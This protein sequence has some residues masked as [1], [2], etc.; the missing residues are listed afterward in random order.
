MGEIA[1]IRYSLKADNV[2]AEQAVQNLFTPGQLSINAIWRK[3]N[4]IEEADDEVG[5]GL[6]Q[7][8]RNELQLVV[9]HPDRGSGGGDRCGSGSESTVHPD[10]GV[11]GFAVIARRRNNVVV[12]RP[13]GVVGEAL[14][15]VLNVFFVEPHGHERDAV[16]IERR[17][18]AISDAGPADPGAV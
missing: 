11:P 7:Q 14:V 5:A 16:I 8:A 6:P 2:G 9:V 10:V 18:G 17:K 12:E 1:G 4:V 13:E 15:V 3:W